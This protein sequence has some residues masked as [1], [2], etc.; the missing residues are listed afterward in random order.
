[1]WKLNILKDRKMKGLKNLECLLPETKNLLL[2]LIND[3]D[4]LHKYVLAGGSAL[5]LRVCHIMN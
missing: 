1:M 4:L 5:T 2:N 3:C